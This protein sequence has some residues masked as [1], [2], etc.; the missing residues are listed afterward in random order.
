DI[1][2]GQRRRIPTHFEPGTTA[3][4]CWSPDGSRLALNLLNDAN[5]QGSIEVV[6]LNGPNFHFRKLTLPA[7]RWNLMVCDWKVLAPDIHLE[8]TDPPPDTKTL[9]GRYQALIQEV[10]KANRIY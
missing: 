2:G 9:R 3:T 4:V 5:K 7:G 10:E 8:T 1:E 6:D